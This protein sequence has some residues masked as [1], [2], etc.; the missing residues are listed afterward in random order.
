MPSRGGSAQVTTDHELIRSWV[1]E[2]GGHPAVVKRTRGRGGPRVM[3]IDYPGYSGEDTLEAIEWDDFF[4][5]F[6]QRGLAF[7]HQD[8]TPEGEPS[9]FSKLVKRDSVAARGAQRVPSSRRGATA[10]RSAARGTAKGGARRGASGGRTRAKAGS[11]RKTART[12]TRQKTRRALA[13]RARGVN[14]AGRCSG[15]LAA[16]VGRCAGQT[17]VRA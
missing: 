9:R 2:R 6:D 3:R 17:M 4:K 14:C 16:G 15:R 13:A 1:E 5:A 7:L 12:Q 8:R 10:S 11:A